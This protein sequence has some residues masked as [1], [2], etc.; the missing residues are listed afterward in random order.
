M[1]YKLLKSLQKCSNL[2]RNRKGDHACQGHDRK[3]ASILG[4]LLLTYNTLMVLELSNAKYAAE[5]RMHIWVP[6]PVCFPAIGM[7]YFW[8]RNHDL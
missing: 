4:G 2:G 1:T 5:F 3:R 7:D 8:T 6:V